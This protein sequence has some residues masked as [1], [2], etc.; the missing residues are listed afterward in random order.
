MQ[1]AEI[2]QESIVSYLP[3]S[4]VAAQIYDLWTG[5]QWG[6]LVYFAQPDA[7]KVQKYILYTLLIYNTLLNIPGY[8]QCVSNFLILCMVTGKVTITQN[9][10]AF[11]VNMMYFYS[12]AA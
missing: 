6:E 5:I 4:H 12:R 3:L 10:R 8:M 7:L 1:P 9:K 2:K 11:S